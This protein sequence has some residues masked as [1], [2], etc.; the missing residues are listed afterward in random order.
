[1]LF[2]KTGEY[3]LKHSGGGKTRI[4]VKDETAPTISV[5]YSGFNPALNQSHA[6]PK[7]TVID[8]Y[9]GAITDYSVKVDG[10]E[11]STVV[12]TEYGKKTMTVAATDA[13]GNMAEKTF[14]IECLPDGEI[15]VTAGQTIN[16]GRDFFYG[17]DDSKTY[18]FTFTIEKAEL[19]GTGRTE[20]KFQSRFTVES[21]YYYEVYGKAT[22]ADG[23]ET[24]RNYKLY[25]ED[26][27]NMLAFSSK[28]NGKYTSDEKDFYF[29][30]ETYKNEKGVTILPAP[31]YA[32]ADAQDGNGK[33]NV[34]IGVSSPRETECS[35][36]F[37]LK[38]VK[39]SGT[40][41]F[42][43]SVEKDV[44][45]GTSYVDS[46]MFEIIKDEQV[47]YFSGARRYGVK[48]AANENDVVCRF[49]VNGAKLTDNTVYLDNILFVPD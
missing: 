27:V 46:W 32:K 23:G 47:R 36:S 29:V 33:L 21:G 22:S 18:G 16:L 25:C 40:L 7:I 8:G 44:P 20:I 34:K 37:A 45:A 5:D 48:V 35:W 42:D 13:S 49:G 10:Q 39:A 9:D 4:T 12:F 31:A 28:G 43:L 6:L 30:Y 19:I 26:G 3:V 11:S 24:V 14:P 38:G 41:Y 1:M 15:T 2:S 17:L